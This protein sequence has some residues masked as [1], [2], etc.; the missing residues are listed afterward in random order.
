MS[1]LKPCP[2]CGSGDIEIFRI[3]KTNQ[4]R[5]ECNNCN[6]SKTQKFMRLTPERLTELMIEKWNT[7]KQNNEISIDRCDKCKNKQSHGDIECIVFC[8]ENKDP[9]RY[10]RDRNHYAEV[11]L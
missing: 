1:E 5:I 3:G 8:S 2:F 9:S 10:D 7:R 4:I 6:I 11:L